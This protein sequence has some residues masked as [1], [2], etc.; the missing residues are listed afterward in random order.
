MLLEGHCLCG[1]VTYTVD[2]D[3]VFIAV[4]HCTNCQRQTGTASSLIVGV[5]AERLE[6]RGDSLRMFAT[7]GDDHGTNTNRHFCSGCGSPI[8][9]RID[10]M[11]AVAFIKAGTLNDTSWLQPK[12]E[13]WCRSAQSWVPAI[14]GAQ[15]LDRGPS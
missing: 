13:I 9:T 8:V 12:L 5:P 11:P 7:T 10:A 3:P 1:E 6:I 15:R 14:P 4:C 2:G